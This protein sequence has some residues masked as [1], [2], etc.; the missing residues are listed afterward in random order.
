MHLLHMMKEQSKHSSWFVV[1]K[2]TVP[3]S[4]QFALFGR[5]CLTQNTSKWTF[6]TNNAEINEELAKLTKLKG[7]ED[8]TRPLY[9][10]GAEY[11]FSKQ[12]G[13]RLEYENF[14][15]FGDGTKTELWSLGA[16]Y[17]F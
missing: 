9:G 2:G 10:L 11:S 5:F 13:L 17:S 15:K 14:G 8:K 3:L 1:A 12:F 16:R 7:S 6:K 4:E